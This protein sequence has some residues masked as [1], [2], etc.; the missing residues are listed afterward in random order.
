MHGRRLSDAFFGRI[1]GMDDFA[2]KRMP[3]DVFFLEENAGNAFYPFGQLYS[4]EQA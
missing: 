3:D 1:E 4:S 2:Y